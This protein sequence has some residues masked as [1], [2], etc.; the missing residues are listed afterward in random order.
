VHRLDRG[1]SG[2]LLVA[3]SRY[4]SELLRRKLH[5]EGF[6]REYLA[7]AEGRLNPEEG[8]IALPLGPAEG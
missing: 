5:T 4:V 1:T 6:V 2:L 7:L 8:E 3:R